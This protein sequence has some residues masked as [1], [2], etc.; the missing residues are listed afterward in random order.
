M[1]KFFRPFALAAW[2]CA[3]LASGLASAG[4]FSVHPIR[5]ELGGALRSGVI[6]V[7]NEGK[8][9]LTFQLQAMAWT[10]DASGKD[11]YA[12]TSDLIF[13]PKIMSVEPGEEGLVRVGSKNAVVP[14]ERT[15]RLF[16]EELPGVAK[17]AE[18]SGA[19]INVLIRFG[20]PVFIKP[21]TPQDSLDIE[22]L[23]LARGVVT[24]RAKNTGNGHQMVQGIELKGADAQ[25]NE[26]YALTLADRYLLAGTTKSYSTTIAAD[27]CAKIATL[28]LD[29]K[30]DK[31]SV[32]RK[33]DVTRAMC[34]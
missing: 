25:G 1:T 7:R 2:C 15:Y 31:L 30:T 28:A 18:G 6:G 10:Q 32:T 26:V 8:E 4:E 16:I 34:P 19:Q 29:F 11:E 17:K 23:A 27:Q 20:A 24:L 13:F 5:L 3:L 9:K 21:L 33:L 12:D 14:T 22:S